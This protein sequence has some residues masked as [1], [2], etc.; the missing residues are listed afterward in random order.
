M[1]PPSPILK[2]SNTGADAMSDDPLSDCI[3]M[4]LDDS[5]SPK[6]G[7]GCRHVCAY[8]VHTGFMYIGTPGETVS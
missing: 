2:T 5:S 6:D 7:G 1:E 3:F 8:S 4:I